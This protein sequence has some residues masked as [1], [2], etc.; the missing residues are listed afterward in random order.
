MMRLCLVACLVSISVSFS[1]VLSGEQSVDVRDRK[2]L[3]ID[4]ALLDKNDG[5]TFQVHPPVKQGAVIVPELPSEAGRVGPCG[6][7]VDN[8]G[9]LMMWTTMIRSA[10]TT[11]DTS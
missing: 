1:P 11:C 10:Q 7:V 8:A 5:L 2:Q 4:D 9:Q 6:S 3:F